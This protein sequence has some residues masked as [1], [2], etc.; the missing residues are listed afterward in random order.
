MLSFIVG[1]AF[2]QE[3]TYVHVVDILMITTKQ[4][5]GILLCFC[6]DQSCVAHETWVH[7]VTNHFWNRVTL[8]TRT[9]LPFH[10][11]TIKQ[12]EASFAYQ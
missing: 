8:F 11:S 3:I 5:S 6:Q 4:I 7:A 10:T 12:R 1:G 2:F 9:D